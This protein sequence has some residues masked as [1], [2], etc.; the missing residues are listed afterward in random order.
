MML[1]AVLRKAAM[2]RHDLRAVAGAHAG[3]VLTLGDVADPVQAVLDR[4]VRTDP[5]GEQPWLGVAVVEGGD[6]VDGLHRRLGLA[7]GRR[8]RTTL[9]ARAPCGNSPASG[10]PSRSMTLTERDSIRPC[11][12]VRSRFPCTWARGSRASARRSVGWL[13]LT[14]NR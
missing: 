3:V 7:G 10:V 13:P 14:V 11:P 8:R 6:R 9:I 12:T 5:G 1:I 2:S 4:P